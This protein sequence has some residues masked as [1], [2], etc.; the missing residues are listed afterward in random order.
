MTARIESEWIV[1][2]A[3]VRAGLLPPDVA[4]RVS[5]LTLGPESIMKKCPTCGHLYFAI[6][7]DCEFKP[8]NEVEEDDIGD[9]LEQMAGATMKP[10]RLEAALRWMGLV[11]Q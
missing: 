10:E 8:G 9:L 3:I 6:C 4:L 5:Q 11:R 1:L 2:E 7:P